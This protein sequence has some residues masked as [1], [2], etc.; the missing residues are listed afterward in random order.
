MTAVSAGADSAK[1]AVFSSVLGESSARI[2]RT[3][4]F[5][6]AVQAAYRAGLRLRDQAEQ[7]LAYTL[8]ID[9]NDELFFDVQA[10]LLEQLPSAKRRSLRMTTS[11]RGQDS[12]SPTTGS[13]STTAGSGSVVLHF[14]G[15]R[16][17]VL[18]FGG[19]RVKVLTERDGDSDPQGNDDKDY[20]RY[21]KR[22]RITFTARSADGRDAV[23]SWLEGVAAARSQRQPRLYIAARWG[24]WI[25]YDAAQP[26]SM[27]SVVLSGD[28]SQDLEADLAR[29]IEAEEGYARLGI[30][31]H[32]GYVF[33]GPPG[34]GK[35]SLA[36]ALATAFGLDVYYLPL[37]DIR[38]D[39]NLVSLLSNVQRRSLLLIEDVDIAKA[40][41]ERTDEGEGVSLSGLLNALDGIVTPH[42]LIT[43]M[44]TNNLDALDEA[45][46]RPGRAD[47]VVKIDHMDR[48]QLLRLVQALT[49]ESVVDL[50]DPTGLQV[51]PA[52][53]VEALKA[54]IGDED[55]TPAVQAVSN[56]I[57]DRRS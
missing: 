28:I 34:T 54:Y 40:A 26:R 31:W 24:D 8:S 13:T 45:L 39:T 22:D 25:L 29:F 2:R 11:S 52:D 14:D 32:R 18:T 56:M 36:R 19:H 46:V 21:F 12:S 50:P 33:H 23:V 15:R 53:V 41:T 37:S 49:D 30:P 35:T 47:R 48:S 1:T 5:G 57:S 7:K 42:G 10:Y 9:S 27:A 4:A 20:R 38:D 3:V 16:Q 44:T 43:V 17:Q 51:T 6:F 55:Q